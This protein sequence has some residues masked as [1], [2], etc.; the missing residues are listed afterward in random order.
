MITFGMQTTLVRFQYQYYNYKGVV[1]GD[2]TE[3][4]EDNNGLAIGAYESA[5]CAD[6]SATYTYDMCDKIFA[7]LRYTGLYQDDGLA[8]FEGKKTRRQT[9]T[10]LCDFQLHVNE[11]VGR[12][13]L[14]FTAELWSS[15]GRLT[16]P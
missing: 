10:W 9:I 1:A 3:A 16:L 14:Q 4:N 5:F 15:L 8:I 12:D 6:I 2:K 13:F 11:V 7:K